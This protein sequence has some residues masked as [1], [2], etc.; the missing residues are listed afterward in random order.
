MRLATKMKLYEA[1]YGTSRMAR[2]GAEF[3]IQK[4]FRLR[5]G[6]G[7]ETSPYTEA[8]Q[9]EANAKRYQVSFGWG[10]RNRQMVRCNDLSSELD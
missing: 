5:F 6:A 2:V 8:A 9:V 4:V 1:V 3:R 7:M 10:V